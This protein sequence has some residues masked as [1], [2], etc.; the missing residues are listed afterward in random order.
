[1]SNKMD[2]SS[3]VTIMRSGSEAFKRGESIN[4]CP[5]SSRT[6]GNA[7]CW[8]EDGWNSA[9]KEQEAKT[10]KGKNCNATDEVEHSSECHKEHDAIYNKMA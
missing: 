4:D 3:P 1:M 2:Y 5:I 7:M 10:C 8:W 6:G 9:R